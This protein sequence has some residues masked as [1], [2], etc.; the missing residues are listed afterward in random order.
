MAHTAKSFDLTP[1]P[2]ILPMLGQIPLA[3]WKC[4]AELLDNCIDAFM[5]AE[6]MGQS[7]HRPQV[8]ITC[9]LNAAPSGQVTIRDN[10][11]GMDTETLER[12][13]KAGWSGRDPINNLGLFGMGFN[14]ATARLCSRT[15][16]WTTRAGDHQWTGLEIDFEKLTKHSNFLTSALNRPKA[17]TS[18]SGTEVVLERLKPEMR[19][20]FAKGANRTQITRNLGRTYSAIL[21]SSNAA[22]TDF[23]LEFNGSVVRAR[24]HCIWGGP[25]NPERSVS[26]PTLGL[27]NAYQDFDFQLPTRK[28]CVACWTWVGAG[29][30]ECPQCGS[31]GKVVDRVRRVRGWIGVQRYQDETD[32]G[33]DLLRNG[34]KIEIGCKDLFNWSDP[35]TDEDIIEYPID[36]QRHRGRIVGEIH[37]DHC[38][39]PYTKERFLR[40]DAAWGEMV[41]LVRG[42]TPLQPRI[43]ESRGLGGNTSPLYKLYQ[44]FRRSSPQGRSGSWAKLLVVRD[45]DRAREMA[46]RFENGEPEYQSDAKWYELAQEEDDRNLSAGKSAGGGMTLGGGAA[47]AHGGSPAGVLGSGGNQ[48]VGAASS[49][50][51]KPTI[52]R[53]VLHD[54][55]RDYRDDLTGQLFSVK[56]FSAAPQDPDL[57]E[58]PWMARK[59]SSGDWEFIVNLGHPVFLSATLTPL[60]AL[61]VHLAHHAADIEQSQNTGRKFPAILTSLRAKFADRY[62][63]V[64]ADLSRK[65]ANAI[66][67][68]AASAAEEVSKETLESFFMNECSATMQEHIRG[69]MA[70]RAAPNPQQA[71][72]DGRFLQYAP[73]QVVVDFFQRHPEEFFDGAF[74]DEPYADLDYGSSSATD[75]ARKR[76]LAYYSSL[77]ADAV[78][79]SQLEEGAEAPATRERLLRA[80]L[81][82]DLLA[83]TAMV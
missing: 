26:H 79:L 55:T 45:D 51:P 49:S 17:E 37:L 21:S 81:A 58:T 23:K 70:R 43:A 42:N 33:I 24:P 46:R 61:L 77:L 31:E 83:P 28:F 1:H 53:Q 41:S 10:G 67:L 50:P 18:E 74:W 40:E 30:T 48:P 80:S 65:A 22:M 47:A 7:I 44:A 82:A 54:L 69:A 34:R 25:G 73:P 60:D 13:A 19:E 16:V 63:L 3:Q 68:L 11:P 5:E 4:L 64:T 78:W 20:W 8:V 52:P 56:A 35:N 9:P 2:R 72:Q 39:V 29:A 14:I 32:F 57:G 27:I 36:D 59:T 76:V 75:E 71:I 38:Q 15:T 66:K 62:N 6:R 12:A